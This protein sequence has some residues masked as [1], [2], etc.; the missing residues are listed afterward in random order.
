MRIGIDA[1]P[2]GDEKRTGI[3]RCLHR[4]LSVWSER[5]TNHEFFLLTFKPLHIDFILPSNW[6][7]IE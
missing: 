5:E 6:H 1:S 3:G 4:I 7:I 2:L